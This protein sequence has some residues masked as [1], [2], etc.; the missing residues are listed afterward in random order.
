MDINYD[1]ESHFLFVSN[2]YDCFKIFEIVLLFKYLKF[3]LNILD[4]TVFIH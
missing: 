4:K 3:L 1:F 2:K